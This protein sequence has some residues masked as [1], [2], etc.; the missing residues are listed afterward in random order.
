[1]PRVTFYGSQADLTPEIVS[2]AL[3]L[4]CVYYPSHKIGFWTPLE[5]LLAY[6]WA[7]REH[8]SASDNPVQRR[9]RPYFLGQP[10][11]LPGDKVRTDLSAIF[12]KYGV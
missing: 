1:M 5:R 11:H 7:M 3:S 10:G 12:A 4:A 6:D 8:M 9:P 2:D